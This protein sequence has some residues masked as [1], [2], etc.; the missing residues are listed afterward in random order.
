M[1]KKARAQTTDP[2]FVCSSV[3]AL[4]TLL[5]RSNQLRFTLLPSAYKHH[6][7]PT[8]QSMLF[9]IYHAKNRKPECFVS[10]CYSCLEMPSHRHQQLRITR[11]RRSLWYSLHCMWNILCLLRKNCCAWA[12]ARL[13]VIDPSQSLLPV[14]FTEHS[15]HEGVGSV[16][17]SRGEALSV[18][19]LLY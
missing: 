10:C 3:G 5:L 18:L 6:Y 2:V 19:T 11:S 8:L 14:I 16:T 13:G 7:L 4:T 15:V 12:W 17:H 1:K 9:L